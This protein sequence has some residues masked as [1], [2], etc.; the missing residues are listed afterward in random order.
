M[1][2]NVQL[3]IR[4]F[5]GAWQLM[6]GASPGFRSARGDGIE[7]AFSGLSIG[8][9]NAAILT[10]D[11][12]SARA[13]EEHG[14]AAQTWASDQD[15]PY[16]FVVTHEALQ[17][18]VDAV[19]VLDRCGLGQMMPVTGM[20]ATRIA[21]PARVPPDSC[22]LELVVPVDDAGCAAVLDANSLAYGLDLEAAKTVLGKRAF[23]QGHVPVVG[24][25]AGRTACSAA[26]LDVDGHR[27]VCLVA[28]DPAQQRRG[29][30]EAAMR[31]ALEL[32]AAAHGERPTVLHATEAGRPVYERMGYETLSTHTFFMEK[33]YLE[34]H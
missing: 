23:W 30:A 26:V 21:P 17:P 34:G 15:V 1:N 7:Y 18:G 14:R 24:R 20:R 6:C 5:V 27:Y 9:F 12:L 33:K 4:Q 10:Q 13:L 2:T 3:S 32:S 8:F 22:G 29:F 28:T 25:V 11:E 31:R 16:L 19:A